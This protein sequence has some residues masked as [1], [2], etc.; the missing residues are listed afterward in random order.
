[1]PSN[2]IFLSGNKSEVPGFQWLPSSFMAAH[3][4]GFAGSQLSAGA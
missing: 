2:V 1:M 3:G 4:V